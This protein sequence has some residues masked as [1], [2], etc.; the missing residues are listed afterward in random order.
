[1]INLNHELITK[2]EKAYY[3]SLGKRE[4]EMTF[5]KACYDKALHIQ[6]YLL[7][8]KDF[9]KNVDINAC[10]GACLLWACYHEEKEFVTWLMTSHELK[11]HANL[12]LEND[13]IFKMVCRDCSVDF[14]EFILT[15]PTL[16]THP[17]FEK[18]AQTALIRALSN[19]NPTVF[20][21]LFNKALENKQITLNLK[22]LLEEACYKGNKSHIDEILKSNDNFHI[23]MDNY[24]IFFKLCEYDHLAAFKEIT[25]SYLLSSDI[26]E[27]GLRKNMA[28]YE[29]KIT[30]YFL[31][32]EFE[33]KTTT[34]NFI[35]K[36]SPDLSYLFREQELKNLKEDLDSK[37]T[38]NEVNNQRY[39]I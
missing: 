12:H 37:L 28:S 9:K 29:K 3:L 1:M 11:K 27:K 20:P 22:K 7:T 8:S 30:H 25:Q 13:K 35:I 23:F 19:Y 2:E 5:S 39:K 4:L 34:K 17:S 38:T 21:F 15:S 36:K 26:I 24:T 16:P 18:I 10:Q 32:K 31:S 6:H 33:I 14:I